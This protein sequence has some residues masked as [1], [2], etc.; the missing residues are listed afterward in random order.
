[1]DDEYANE[2]TKLAVARACL[3]LGF[4]QCER[5]ALDS[6]ADI[7]QNY[8]RMLGANAQEQTEISGRVHAGIQDLIP[9]LESTVSYRDVILAWSSPQIISSFGFNFFNR[10]QNT[11]I[12]KSFG[13][14][15]L[16]M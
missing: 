7:L 4:K 11:P 6:M 12:G 1:M 5:S 16:R 15:H 10:D 2:I 13:H 14:L 8:M 3:A 9:V